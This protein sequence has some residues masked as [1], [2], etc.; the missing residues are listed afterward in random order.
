MAGKEAY[1]DNSKYELSLFRNYR[2]LQNFI[3]HQADESWI[4][5]SRRFDYLNQIKFFS[6]ND[7]AQYYPN[8]NLDELLENFDA[9]FPVNDKHFLSH[10]P[11]QLSFF[12]FSHI[13]NL[14]DYHFRTFIKSRPESEQS[15]LNTLE[16][17]VVQ[18]IEQNQINN[19]NE[20]IAVI[21]KW[22]R[23][24]REFLELKK[25][26]ASYANIVNNEFVDSSVTFIN[27]WISNPPAPVQTTSSQPSRKSKP[28]KS[29]PPKSEFEIAIKNSFR[30][31]F[32][33]EIFEFIVEPESN[34]DAFAYKM[35]ESLK[36]TPT[37]IGYRLKNRQIAK[38]C[39]ILKKYYDI[40]KAFIGTT[41][42]DLAQWIVLN[43]TQ[44]KDTEEHPLSH[45]TI[46]N[47][48]RGSKK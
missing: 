23:G 44:Q 48:L 29:E 25:S 27:N 10:L 5:F 24:K 3:L 17:R 26:H 13:E 22:V 4:W 40:K 19:F 2:N 47:H 12:K 36:G 30:D 14:L 15:F 45:S 9:P 41:K 1:W 35:K 8:E 20:V 33:E 37:N 38:F 11:I 7:L 43:F 21:L 39:R 34:F 28:P 31:A 32:I 16:N 6:K 18:V 42:A 46:Y